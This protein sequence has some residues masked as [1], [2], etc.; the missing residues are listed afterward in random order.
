[1]RLRPIY[2]VTTFVPQI[3]LEELLRGVEGI[4]AAGGA[5]YDRLVWWSEAVEQFRPLPGATPVQ[6]E[7]GRVERVATLRV[8]FSIPRGPLLLD[9]FLTRL[10]ELHPWDR[11][12]IFVD[13]SLAPLEEAPN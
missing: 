2:R 5:T 8:E 3:Q 9:A 10:T 4:A 11:P 7:I 6:G 12:T 13:E 1:M